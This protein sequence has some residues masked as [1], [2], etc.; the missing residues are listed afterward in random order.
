MSALIPVFVLLVSLAAQAVFCGDLRP[1]VPLLLGIAASV[2]LGIARGKSWRD[3]SKETFAAAG[4]VPSVLML[5]LLIGPLISAW[6]ASGT[7]P[8]LILCGREIITPVTYLPVTFALMAATGTMMG[9]G[10]SALGTMGIALLGVG[11]SMGFPLSLIAGCLG[12][13]AFWGNAA[14]PMSAANFLSVGVTGCSAEDYNRLVFRQLAFPFVF[15]L[16]AYAALGVFFDVSAPVQGGAFDELRALFPPRFLSFL[17]PLLMIVMIVFRVPTLPVFFISIITA[18]FAGLAAGT[19]APSQLPSLITDGYRY[20]GADMMLRAM[21]NRGGI[22]STSSILITILLAM[23]FGGSYQAC[24]ALGDL[25]TVLT[26]KVKSPSSLRHLAHL[27]C[28]L[29]MVATGSIMM[30]C[31]LVGTLFAP[32][33]KKAGL[34]AVDL[35]TVI[36]PLAVALSPI[37]PWSVSGTALTNII[38]LS[39]SGDIS[40]LLYIPLCF[41]SFVIPVWLFFQRPHMPHTNTISRF[42]DE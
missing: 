22:S 6:I 29:V 18:L 38:G 15:L 25:L 11:Q 39:L 7:L 36:G 24:G 4:S 19:I 10:I 37:I 34:R 42:K 30:T 32:Q 23:V 3:Q 31:A 20:T 5:Y 21:L 13:G 2:V 41:T 9:S 27:C 1:Y 16:A 17:P 26:K 28:T 8:A 40:G 33:A 35:A 12:S 14:S